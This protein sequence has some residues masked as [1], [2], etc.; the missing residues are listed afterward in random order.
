MTEAVEVYRCVTCGDMVEVVRNGNGTLMCCGQNMEKLSEK[1]ADT[2]KEKHVP[3]VHISGN[4]VMVKTGSI[5]HPMEEKHYIEW[6]EVLTDK[7]SQRKWLKP[8]MA[9]EAEFCLQGNITGVRSFCNVH[10]LW[11]S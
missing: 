10:G 3:V 8:G 5:P 2:G 7:G 4:K 6:I 1:T 9:P 11:K